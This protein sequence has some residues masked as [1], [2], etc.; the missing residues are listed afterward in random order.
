[1]VLGMSGPGVEGLR[2]GD[3]QPWCCSG[4]TGSLGATLA[5]RVYVCSHVSLRSSRAE[6]CSVEALC[7][8]GSSSY[9]SVISVLCV[10]GVGTLGTHPC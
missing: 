1:M 2:Q 10:L 9:P 8:P 4:L 6:S 7:T 3:R 5:G